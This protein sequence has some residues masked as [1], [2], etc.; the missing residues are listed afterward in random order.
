M[1]IINF[2]VPEILERKIKEVIKKK[3]FSSKAELFRFAVL[4]YLEETEKFPLDNNPRITAL[5]N[6]LEREMLEKLGESPLPDIKV[7]LKRM[8]KV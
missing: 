1:A 5:S 7:Q 4:R 6:A 3:G 2:S 8:K